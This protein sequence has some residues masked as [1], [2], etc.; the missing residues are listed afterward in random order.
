MDRLKAVWVWL[1][2]YG[3]LIAI[4]IAVAVGV[5]SYQW[6]TARIEDNTRTIRF[7]CEAVNETNADQVRMLELAR[8]AT[9]EGTTVQR[10]INDFISHN[11]EPIECPS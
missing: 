3:W 4:V 11:L 10:I 5:W 7:V 6:N 2:S 9:E 1:V 8:L